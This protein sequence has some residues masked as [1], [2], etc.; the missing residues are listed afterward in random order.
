MR[1]VQF[2]DR[3]ILHRDWPEPKATA[4]EAV[5]RV[6]RAGICRTDLEIVKGYMSFHGILGHE[7]VGRVCQGPARWMGKRVVAEI[8]CVCGRCDMCAGGLRNHCRNRTVLGI[9]G[10]DGAFAD[11]VLVPVRNLHAVPDGVGDDEATLV[12]PLAAAF[13]LVHQI[14]FDHMQRVVVLGDG[15]LGQL[16]SRV[17]QRI[18]P[19][20]VLVGK[21]PEKLALADRLHIQTA[22]VDRFIPR[23]EADVVVEATGAAEGLELACR[24]VRPR[25]TIALKSTY[26]GRQAVALAPVVVDEITIVGS[27]CG[28]FGD[29]LDALARGEVNVA[30]LI[31]RRLPLEK[32]EEA[33]ELARRPDVV[34]VMFDV[35]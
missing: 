21:H 34:K 11:L 19:Q 25:G 32:A 13:Q 4:E 26:A 5:V 30:N 27:R 8:N 22:H 14:R 15:R 3:I 31:G 2:H 35:S 23:Q 29:A 9:A 7:F 6:I 16:V 1:A 18:C 12:E 33:F 10:R 20:L 17:L 24:T 28:P